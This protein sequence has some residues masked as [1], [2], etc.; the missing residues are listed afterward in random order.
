MFDLF[1]MTNGAN[2]KK[3]IVAMGVVTGALLIVHYYH[4]I[5]LTRLQIAEHEEKYVHT[6]RK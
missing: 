1:N 5:K 4:Q 3:L 6:K 2:N